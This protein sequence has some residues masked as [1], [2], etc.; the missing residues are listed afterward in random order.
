M[1]GDGVPDLILSD[2]GNNNDTGKVFWVSGTQTPDFGVL[3]STV[4][5]WTGANTGDEFGT[6]MLVVEDLTNDGVSELLVGAQGSGTV[7]LLDGSIPG[8]TSDSMWSWASTTGTSSDFGRSIV[9]LGDMDGDGATEF[10][11]S[12]PSHLVRFAPVHDP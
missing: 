7:Y 5:A 9:S 8:T 3:D 12:D 2:I 6:S 11:V 4:F 10:V 1:D